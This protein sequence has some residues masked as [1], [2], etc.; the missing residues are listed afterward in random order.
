MGYFRVLLEEGRKKKTERVVY[1]QGKDFSTVLN[2]MRR[3][4]FGKLLDA[5]PVTREEYLRGVATKE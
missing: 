3:F 1:M 4:N 5:F 2:N